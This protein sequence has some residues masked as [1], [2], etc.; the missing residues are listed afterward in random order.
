MCT[1]AW[2]MENASCTLV[3]KDLLSFWIFPN[4]NSPPLL[5]DILEV[6]WAVFILTCLLFIPLI[7]SL[8]KT[9]L[10]SSL[11]KIL[12]NSLLRLRDKT[13]MQKVQKNV[14]VSKTGR[15]VEACHFLARHSYCSHER[16]LL[17]S[18]LGL[19]TIMGHFHLIHLEHNCCS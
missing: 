14:R 19:H 16:Q 12:I 17:M 4:V 15:R 2:Q 8:Q 1:L 11:N 6:L 3:K 13:L 7:M 10:F 18:A 9:Y 5:N